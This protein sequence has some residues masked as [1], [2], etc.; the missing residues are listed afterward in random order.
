[1][2]QVHYSADWYLWGFPA[3]IFTEEAGRP[4]GYGQRLRTGDGRANIT[5]PSALNVAN[6]SPAAVLTK[7]HPPSRIQYKRVPRVSSRFPATRRQ[8]LVRSLQF[9]GPHG[10]LLLIN[11][12]AEEEHALDDVV[13]RVSLSLN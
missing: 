1:M 9:F 13:T 7:K 6:D 12:P 10:P 3:S 2:D 5:I 8:G 11:Y 4:D